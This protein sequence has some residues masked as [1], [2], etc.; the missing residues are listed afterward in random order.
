M[1]IFIVSKKLTPNLAGKSFFLQSDDD[2]PRRFF[3]L[4]R[5]TYFFFDN[6]QT[7]RC[8]ISVFKKFGNMG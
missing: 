8:I 1:E 7:F 3:F 2:L 5:N 6:R 4:E